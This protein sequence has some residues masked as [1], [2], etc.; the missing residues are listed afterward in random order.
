MVMLYPKRYK[1][2]HLQVMFDLPVKSKKQRKAATRFRQF[3]LKSGFS[4]QQYSIYLKTIDSYDAKQRWCR[5]IAAEIP[6]DGKVSILAITSKQYEDMLIYLN[7]TKME[8]PDRSI[9]Q[10][11]IF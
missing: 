4:M 6:E 8:P 3:L 9:Q 2:L 1:R 5:K 10:F 7:S 11:L